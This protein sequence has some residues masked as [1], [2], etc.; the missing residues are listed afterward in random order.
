[1]GNKVAVDTGANRGIGEWI[2]LLLARDGMSV[3]IVYRKSAGPARKVLGAVRKS[4][5]ESIAVRADVRDERQAA[6]AIAAAVK[7]YGRLDV[8][9]NNVGDFFLTPVSDMKLAEWRELFRSNL[10]SA[11]NCTKAALPV[12]R[13]QKS[14]V[15]VNLGGPVS[16]QV[17]GNPRAFAY[18]MAKT[19]LV[20]FTKSLARAEAAKGIRV[21]I[22]NPG[23]IRT[24]ACGAAE[25]RQMAAAVPMR[26]LGTPADIAS[27]VSFLASDEAAYVTGAVLDVGGGLWV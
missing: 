27:A 25:A 10:D 3:V 23:Y 2:A 19:G 20:A 16:Q 8:L 11:F 4:S 24:Y 1:M 7:A 13:R 17:R 22:V 21:N 5:P 9:V 15:V 26:R 12:M 18:A 14:G 6:R